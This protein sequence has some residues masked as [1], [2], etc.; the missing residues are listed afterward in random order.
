MSRS[1]MGPVPAEKRT[2]IEERHAA[3]MAALANHGDSAQ[4]IYGWRGAGDF[5]TRVDAEHRPALTQ[6][7]RFGSAV[8]EEANIWLGVV[9]TELRVRGNP[10]RETTVG[11]V[12]APDAGLCRTNACTIQEL[13]EAHHAGRRA[14]LVGD[15]KDMLSLAHAA[16]RLQR[17]Q[18]AGHPDLIAFTS[19]EQVVEYADYDPAGSDLEVAVQ[20]IDRYG[21]AGVIAAIEG[22]VSARH[23]D[24]VVSTAHRSKGLEWN[25]VRIASDYREPLD[26]GSGLPRPIRV[27]DAML[28]YVSVTRAKHALDFGGLSWVHAHLAIP[29]PTAADTAAPAAIQARVDI[30]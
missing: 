9:G 25:R 6:S 2:K 29:T 7:W 28:A 30:V 12:V 10:A 20:M 18:P 1:R 14:H 24:L 21:T 22:T 23:A 4:A 15:G 5:L 8:A 3:E 26:R 11:P 19:W 13:M 17:H 27:T 16:E